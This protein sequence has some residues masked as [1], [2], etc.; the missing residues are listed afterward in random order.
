ME[1]EL[2]PAEWGPHDGAVIR[3]RCQG[4][5]PYLFKK[6][7]RRMEA[8]LEAAEMAALDDDIARMESF[9]RTLLEADH[10]DEVRDFDRYAAAQARARRDRDRELG[11]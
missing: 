1:C 9:R 7:G 8:G 10:P 3:G 2:D 5:T 11:R 6:W 4:H